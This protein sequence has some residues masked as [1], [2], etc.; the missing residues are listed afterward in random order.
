MPLKLWVTM[1]YIPTGILLTTAT[2]MATRNVKR[3]LYTWE[4]AAMFA[5][6][7]VYTVVISLIW[8]W[9]TRREG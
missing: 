8:L 4:P 6:A 3:E 9:K 1:A 7:A 2:L 5:L